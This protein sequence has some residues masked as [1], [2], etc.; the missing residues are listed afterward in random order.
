MPDWHK[1]LINSAIEAAAKETPEQD[2]DYA[3]TWRNEA[4]PE[5]GE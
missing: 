4:L 2:P 3:R 5:R 1:A